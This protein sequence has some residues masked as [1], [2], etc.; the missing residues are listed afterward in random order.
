MGWKIRESNCLTREDW[1]ATSFTLLYKWKLGRRV[2][3]KEEPWKWTRVKLIEDVKL[4]AKS[5]DLI[6]LIWNKAKVPKNDLCLS[7]RHPTK[8]V[9]KPHTFGIKEK[10]KKMHLAF[11]KPFKNFSRTP[12]S[13]LGCRLDT[14]IQMLQMCLRKNFNY[15]GHL[16]LD[17]P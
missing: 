6:N 16:Y 5:W 9:E 17:K 13:M 14:Y 10:L 11:Q 3:K 4:T 12:T 1:I 2:G 8:G 7:A 15:L